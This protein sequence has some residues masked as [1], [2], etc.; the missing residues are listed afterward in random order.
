M[1]NNIGL[2]FGT[3]YS[4]ISKLKNIEREK[5]GAIRNYELEACLPS[6]AAHS[7][8]QDSIVLKAQDGSLIFGPLA[9]EKTG[10]KGT[11]IYKGFKMMLA[12][13]DNSVL[14]SRGYDDEYTPQ[15]I[16]Q[17][18]LNDI[19]LRYVSGSNAE[20]NEIDK[21]VVGV[22][23]IWFSDVSTI[24]CRTALEDIVSTFPF[25]KKVELVSEPAAACA[26]FVE[27]YKK[28]TRRKYRGKILLVDYGGG[29]LD[30]ALCDVQENGQSS[31][32][33]VIKRCGAG[34][35]EEG[36]IGKAGMAFIEAIVKIALEPAGLTNE[37]IIGN[38]YFYRCVNS[39]ETALMNQMRDIKDTFDF[40]ELADRD[41]MLDLFYTIEFDGE[42]YDV[43][44]GMLSKAY[45][46]I[47]EPVLEEKLTEMIEYMKDN[48]IVY[49]SNTDDSFKIAPVGGFCNFYLTQEQIERKF[50][51]CAGDK[52]FS[53]IINDRRDC[54]KAISYGAALIAEEVI[55][56]K[57]LSPYYLGI[58]SGSEN[59]LKDI[60]YAINKGDDIV[61]D[62][63]VFIKY[64]DGSDALFGGAH[65]PLFVLNLDDKCGKEF[66]QWG[67]PLEE[68]KSK[69]ALEKDMWC[70]I[71][72]SLDRS[73]IIT[74]H[75]QII[76][77]NNPSEV[78]S[79]SS[80][81]LNDIYSILGNLIRVRGILK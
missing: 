71:G 21:V 10:R 70:K 60:Y 43:T 34:L 33:S 77:P 74:L 69:L 6:E 63:P 3:T 66:A 25:V 75:K 36:Y 54:E 80:V 48:N 39:V 5:S 67:E 76:N 24:D 56:F 17:A 50:A 65:I 55:G 45:R 49:S 16:V 61:Y 58:A 73:M 51:R 28:N 78:V 79:Q 81:R 2:D 18:Y 68:Y 14:K 72:F 46:R 40:A 19:L 1:G 32:V 9:R 53:D 35:N 31:E 59:E 64:E 42:E 8:C 26:F 4:V 30:I 7:P 29:T 44:Y 13:T 38:R 20:I 15:K 27:N 41:S 37:E 12:E 47:I 52:R 22:P 23:E 57:Q 62:E 11:T